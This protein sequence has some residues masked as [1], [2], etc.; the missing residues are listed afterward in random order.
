M[1]KL[2]GARQGPDNDPRAKNEGGSDQVPRKPAL[3]VE[4]NS[5]VLSKSPS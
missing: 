4:I 5:F 2:L 3:Q 1:K